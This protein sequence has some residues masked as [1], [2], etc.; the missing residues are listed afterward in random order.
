MGQRVKT[1][2]LGSDTIV[3]CWNS[4]KL[5]GGMICQFN[6]VKYVREGYLMYE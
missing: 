1:G 5:K 6:G 3:T 4:I 2:D